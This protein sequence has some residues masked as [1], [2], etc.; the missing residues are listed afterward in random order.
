MHLFLQQE[1]E[2]FQPQARQIGHS[3]EFSNGSPLL[4]HFFK[5]ELCCFGA[6]GPCQLATCFGIFQSASEYNETEKTSFE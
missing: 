5:K 3:S 4:R 2:G 6:D 1:A